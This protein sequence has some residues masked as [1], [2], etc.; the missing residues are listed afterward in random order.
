LGAP[1]PVAAA[2][3]L[4]EEV[5]LQVDTSGQEPSEREQLV[6]YRWWTVEELNATVET[7][8]PYGLASLLAEL[9]AGRLSPEPVRLPWHY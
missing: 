3:E 6:D 2:R 9:I 4:H 1:L 8:Y 5:G 7:V